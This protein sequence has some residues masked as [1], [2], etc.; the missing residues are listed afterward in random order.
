MDEEAKGILRQ[1]GDKL[2]KLA[3]TLER[4]EKRQIKTT[5]MVSQEQQGSFGSVDPGDE[6]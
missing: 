2:D 4:I 3:E 5:Q 6:V 1:L